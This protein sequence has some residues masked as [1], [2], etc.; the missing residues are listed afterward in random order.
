MKGY[1][2]LTELS[3]DLRLDPLEFLLSSFDG[4]R[5]RGIILQG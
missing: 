5:V 4:L 2:R 3:V 1:G